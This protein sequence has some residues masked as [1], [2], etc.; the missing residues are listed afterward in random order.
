MVLVQAFSFSTLRNIPCYLRV[1]DI[2]KKWRKLPYNHEWLN[3]DPASIYA[4]S[5]ALDEK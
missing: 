1:E 2:W 3:S 5:L 4:A